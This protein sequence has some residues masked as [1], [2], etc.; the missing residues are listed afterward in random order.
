MHRSGTSALCSA[1]E[2]CGVSFGPRLLN[3]MPGINEDGFWEDA[4]VVQ[5]N[6]QLLQ[7]L[8]GTWFALPPGL[9]QADWS[10]GSLEGLREDATGILARGFGAGSLQAV[11]DP[12]LCLTLP[13]WLG[14]CEKQGVPVTVCVMGRAP[15]EVARSLEK[16]DGFPVGY[17]LRLCAQYRKILSASAPTGSLYVTYDDLLGDAAAVMARLAESVPLDLPAEGLEGTVKVQLRH[18]EQ[19]DG[20][21]LLQEAD[22]RRVDPSDLDAVIERNYPADQL[23]PSLVRCFVQRGEQLTALG[24]EHSRTLETLAQRD[25]DVE[26]LSALHREALA[27]IDERDEQIV[28]FDRRLAETGAHLELALNTL[29]ER[30]E[31]MQRILSIPGIGHVLRAAKWIHARR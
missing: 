5:L 15:L 27:T 21:P 9:E 12:R 26:S 23:A 13:F 28:E 29:R 7:R 22:S 18:H 8:G 3:P 14:A 4:D 17:G 24:G 25:R 31:Q 6:E 19:L 10:S 30:D 1:L 16:R 11:K 2:R 20:D